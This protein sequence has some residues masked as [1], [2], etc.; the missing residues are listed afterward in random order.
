MI[1]LLTS[2][3][4]DEFRIKKSESDMFA[5]TQSKS[6]LKIVKLLIILFLK[7]LERVHTEERDRLESALKSK[8][9]IVDT[10]DLNYM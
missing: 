5:A 6:M 2:S 3:L 8:N 7:E 4:L 9:D 1:S 10:Y